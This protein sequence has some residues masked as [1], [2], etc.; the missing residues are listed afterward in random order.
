VFYIPHKIHIP[1]RLEPKPQRCSKHKSPDWAGY[2]PRSVS[3]RS[4]SSANSLKKIA[5]RAWASVIRYRA[6]SSAFLNSPVVLQYLLLSLSSSQVGGKGL[7]RRMIN[8]IDR[9]IHEENHGRELFAYRQGSDSESWSHLVC[10]RP[11]LHPS[12]LHRRRK[13]CLLCYLR[14]PGGSG[15][16][17]VSPHPSIARVGGNARTGRVQTFQIG[18]RAPLVWRCS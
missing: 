12:H 6:V 9:Y 16:W 13:L 15:Y 8:N 7:G 18:R 5:F 4:H 17:V 3:K 2:D 10:H 11:V 1:I 14:Y